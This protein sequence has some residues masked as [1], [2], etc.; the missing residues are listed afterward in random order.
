MWSSYDD[1]DVTE[2]TILDF[3]L[4]PLHFEQVQ[5]VILTEIK[6]C[7][8]TRLYR[9]ICDTH[10]TTVPT[11]IKALFAWNWQ[12]ATL[13]RGDELVNLPLGCLQPYQVHISEYTTADGRR[14]GYGRRFFGVLSLFHESKVTKPGVSLPLF[15]HNRALTDGPRMQKSEPDYSFILPHR[16]PLR[17][18]I[19]AL[20]LMLWFIFDDRKLMSEAPGWD[21]S[22]ASTWRKVRSLNIHRN[23]RTRLTTPPPRQR[24][25]S[26][27][28]LV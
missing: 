18:A 1:F 23:A 3:E 15:S 13:N 8:S 9:R 17:C 12:C 24:S 28:G 19:G 25:C 10:H 11:I 27:R 22:C 20:T 21:W 7:K 26:E 6:Q 16:L 14:S 4:L 5:D 2:N